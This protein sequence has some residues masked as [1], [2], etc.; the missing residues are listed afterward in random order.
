VTRQSSS[1]GFATSGNA[2]FV[3][4]VGLR[5]GPREAVAGNGHA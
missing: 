1:S 4:R 2:L 5:L 3:V